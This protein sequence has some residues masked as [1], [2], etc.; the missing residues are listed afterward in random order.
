IPLELAEQ[1]I[2]ALWDD[3]VSLRA[4]ALTCHAWLSRSRV[5]LFRVVRV[6]SSYQLRSLYH[7]LVDNPALRPLIR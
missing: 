6:V 3:E 5:H 4:C 2:D 1:T 7:L